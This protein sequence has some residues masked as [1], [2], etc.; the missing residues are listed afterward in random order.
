[1]PEACSPLRETMRC[2]V[3]ILVDLENAMDLESP[4]TKAMTMAVNLYMEQ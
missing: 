3:R 1:M 4:R 2:T